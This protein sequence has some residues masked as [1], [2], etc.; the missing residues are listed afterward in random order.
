M[1]LEGHQRMLDQ[2]LSDPPTRGS[3][4]STPMPSLSEVQRNPVLLE[5]LPVGAIVALLRQV[6]HLAADLDAAFY[7][8]VVRSTTDDHAVETPPDRLLTPQ[9]AAE[10]FGVSKRWLLDHA[11]QIAGVRRLSRKVVRFSERELGRFFKRAAV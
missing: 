6:R 4:S 8:A 1:T 2:I 10:Q 3:S 5:A 9:A 7:E 11:G